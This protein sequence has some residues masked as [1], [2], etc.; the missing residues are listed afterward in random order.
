MTYSGSNSSSRSR[1][2]SNSETNTHTS[3]HNQSATA[4]VS[5]VI[6]KRP[7]VTPDEV[8]RFF[9]DPDNP[10]ILVI[11]EGRQPLTLRRGFYFN[12]DRL[13]GLYD[14]HP[15]HPRPLTLTQ[16]ASKRQQDEIARREHEKQRQIEE[17]KRRKEQAA[18]Q[19]RALLAKDR[20]AEQRWKRQQARE[21]RVQLEREDNRRSGQDLVSA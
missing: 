7:L 13:Q 5:E 15:D 4:G 9:G 10:L 14:P 2:I 21:E 6:H 19:A 1:G 20:I 11:Q 8:R 16:L 17:T 3:G 12:N 18:A